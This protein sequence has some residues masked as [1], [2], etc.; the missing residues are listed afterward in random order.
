VFMPV[1]GDGYSDT[2]LAAVANYSIGHF[3]A[4]GGRVTPSNIAK[5]RRD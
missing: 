5:S 3:G 4:N 2:E 1:F